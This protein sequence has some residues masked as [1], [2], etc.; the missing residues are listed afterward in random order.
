MQN[1]EFSGD[2][3]FSEST[4]Y[5]RATGECRCKTSHGPLKFK[6]ISLQNIDANSQIWLVLAKGQFEIQYLDV[7]S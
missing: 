4:T 1:K 6:G 2:P 3:Y 7:N 5:V